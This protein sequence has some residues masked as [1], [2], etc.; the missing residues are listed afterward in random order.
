MHVVKFGLLDAV[1]LAPLS[2]WLTWQYPHTSAGSPCREVTCGRHNIQYKFPQRLNFHMAKKE[3]HTNCASTTNMIPKSCTLAK[4]DVTLWY[5]MSQFS[6]SST[7]SGRG[8]F[9]VSGSARARMAPKIGAV[10][11]M[12]NGVAGLWL[13]SM[14]IIGA[15][16][17]PTLAN[18][19][20]TPN[21][22]CLR[23]HIKTNWSG[24]YLRLCVINVS[25][26]LTAAP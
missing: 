14:L 18:I 23:G 15:N 6:A 26:C 5:L 21:P 25:T 4:T 9:A 3:M 20:E 12:T 17:P 8:L 1:A 2:C 16:T 7:V 13:W 22:V 19:E 11:K 24:H 10:P